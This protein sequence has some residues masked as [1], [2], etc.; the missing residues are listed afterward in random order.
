MV[1]N[2]SH[3]RMRA[4]LIHLL[5]SSMIAGGIAVLVFSI[6]YPYPY[7]HISGGLDLFIILV[8]VDVLAG[9]LVT[10]V[11]FAPTKSRRERGLDMLAVVILQ[12]SALA[13]GVWTMAQARPLQLVYEFGRFGVAHAVE[14]DAALAPKGFSQTEAYPWNGPKMKSL[15]AFRSPE[16]ESVATLVALAGVPLAARADLWQPYSNAVQDVLQQSKPL[17]SLLEIHP[18]REQEIITIVSKANIEVSMVRYLP[19]SARGQFW[20]VFI[21][22]SNGLPV[23]FAPIDSF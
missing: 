14:V 4:A 19:L 11:V 18:T 8:S 1:K 5:M 13:Y 20:T 10:L 23:A 3:V 21:H 22:P 12:V 15:R 7:S 9:P 16:E 6:W 2:I 17:S